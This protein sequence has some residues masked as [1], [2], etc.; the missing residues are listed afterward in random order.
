[1]LPT[2]SNKRERKKRHQCIEEPIADTGPPQVTSPEAMKKKK[3]T[4]A[5]DRMNDHIARD[6][7]RDTRL[8]A[9]R[10]RNF[11]SRK[12]FISKN[13]RMRR[14]AAKNEKERIE[15]QN[16]TLYDKLMQVVV[17]VLRGK[18]LY[19]PGLLETIAKI[20]S[21]PSAGGSRAAIASIISAMGKEYCVHQDPM[22]F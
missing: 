18:R 22:P 20:G 5:R 11:K 10:R 1:M 8:L 2:H 15:A 16:P 3:P 13:F 19:T 21:C 7:K 4:N 6:R 14:K 17:N 12:A 9:R